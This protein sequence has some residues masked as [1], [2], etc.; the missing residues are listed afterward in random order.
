MRRCGKTERRD[1]VKKA[2]GRGFFSKKKASTL[3]PD[4]WA[5]IATSAVDTRPSHTRTCVEPLMKQL[6]LK[7]A[8]S[9]N[10]D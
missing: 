5:Q 7:C 3:S 4:M 2:N 6:G 8:I 10:H 9:K 1:R